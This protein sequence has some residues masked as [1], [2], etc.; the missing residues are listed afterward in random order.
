MEMLV[1]LFRCS[2]IK[3][4]SSACIT[5]R[6]SIITVHLCVYKQ[7]QQPENQYYYTYFYNPRMG[8]QCV[9]SS[10]VNCATIRLQITC[11]F[12]AAMSCM[13]VI[14]RAPCSIMY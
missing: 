6:C 14:E 7:S 4:C 10:T 3:F 11:I 1:Q 13:P 2:A 12:K 5:S 8:L 9:D